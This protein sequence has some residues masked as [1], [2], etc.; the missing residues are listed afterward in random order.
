M[1]CAP[2]PLGVEMYMI[3]GSRYGFSAFEISFSVRVYPSH[4][5]GP[6]PAL[7]VYKS[8][9]RGKRSGTLPRARSTEK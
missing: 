3:G 6:P 7:A 4:P 5:R 1:S 9:G 8:F 2:Q